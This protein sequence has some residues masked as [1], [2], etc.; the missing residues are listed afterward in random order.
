MQPICKRYNTLTKI[1][2]SIEWVFI[3]P[4][5]PNFD[6]FYER[7]IGVLKRMFRAILPKASHLTDETLSTVFCEVEAIVNGR[8]LTKLSQDS[9]DRTPLT[10]NSLLSMS[11][12]HCA[13][14][15]NASAPADALRQRWHVTQV[16]V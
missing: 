13:D 9:H 5:S 3:P 6:G 14:V 2:R 12:R 16:L 7:L 11:M 15:S 8:P 4:K 1:V 10:P